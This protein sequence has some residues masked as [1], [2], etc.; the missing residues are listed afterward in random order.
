MT[1]WLLLLTFVSTLAFAESGD[2]TPIRITF[3]VQGATKA[4]LLAGDAVMQPNR[5]LV[6]ERRAGKGPERQSLV[7]DVRPMEDGSLL[8]RASWNDVSADGATVR[9]EPA[10]LV[11]RGADASVRLDFP[12]GTRALHFTAS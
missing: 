7:L 8:V 5:A 2:E 11:R 12:G 4:P 9:W 6:M 3:S 10:F 1:K